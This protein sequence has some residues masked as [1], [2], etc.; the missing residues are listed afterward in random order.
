MSNPFHGEAGSSGAEDEKMVVYVCEHCGERFEA[1][2]SDVARAVDCPHCG[3]ET[4]LGGPKPAPEPEPEP[5]PEPQ[6]Q[7]PQEV[8]VNSRRRRM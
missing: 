2:E 3:V 4:I 5:R 8:T 7:A 1:A 6:P